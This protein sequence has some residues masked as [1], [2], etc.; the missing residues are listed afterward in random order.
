MD[1]GQ[2]DFKELCE[3]FNDSEE[4]AERLNELAHDTRGDTGYYLAEA[5]VQIQG[6]WQLIKEL[7][8]VHEPGSTEGWK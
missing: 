5:A 8:E 7:M 4:I 2:R 3:V 1:T 6:M